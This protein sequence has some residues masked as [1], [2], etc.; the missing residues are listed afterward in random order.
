MNMSVSLMKKAGVILSATVLVAGLTTLAGDDQA[1]APVGC[2]SCETAPAAVAAADTVTAVVTIT[3]LDPETRAITLKTEEGKEKTLIAGPAV[4]RFDELAVGDK[5]K[6]SYTE[7]VAV[8][9]GTDA[10]VEPSAGVDA[11]VVR[12]PEGAAPGGVAVA[13]VQ[14]TA[15]VTEI[16]LEKRKVKLQLPD[17][18]ERKL[19]VADEIDLSKVKVGDTITLAVVEALAVSVE[20]PE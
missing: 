6:I 2:G 8:S 9:L 3:A 11:T 14:I 19:K 1:A 15:K 17:E 13:S 4:Q 16:N 18:T 5:V 10:T 20:K 7:A 12:T